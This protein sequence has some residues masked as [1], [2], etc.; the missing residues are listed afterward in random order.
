MKYKDFY[1][2]LLSES[3]TTDSFGSLPDRTPYGFVVYPNGKFGVVYDWGGH[4]EVSGGAGQM[5]QIIKKGGLRIAKSNYGEG[6]EAGK[7]YSAEY[8]PTKATD[9][10]KKTGKD[11]ASFYQIPIHF[12]A[13]RWM[14]GLE[15]G[16]ILEDYPATW[17][18]EEFKKINSFAG[19]LRYAREHLQIIA[20]GSGR[21]VFKIDDQKVLKVA[22]NVKG[23][24]QNAVEAEKY[25]QQYDIVAKVF[26]VDEHYL[27]NIGPFYVEMEL[28]KKMTRSRFKAI[29]GVSIDDLDWYLREKRWEEIRRNRYISTLP[30]KLR[31][32]LDNNE[33][34][35]DLMSIS[36]DYDMST[37][38][39]GRLS[40]YGEVVRGGKPTVVMVDF[41]LTNNVYND[42]YKVG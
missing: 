37:G 6:E 12:F 36:S 24:A 4:E 18:L 23:L 26:D 17:N 34:V 5:E 25:L 21:S 14:G 41:G 28:A 42:Y 20:S 13:A 16:E 8:L 38:D 27:K 22:K 31:D 29:T 40:T 9:R 1:E 30:Q 2:E 15:E 3:G 10:A 7:S 35:M 33:F 11:L 32:T 39:M 19:K